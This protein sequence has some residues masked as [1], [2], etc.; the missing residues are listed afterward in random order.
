MLE[1]TERIE[2]LSKQKGISITKLEK[3]LGFS[4]SLIS[5][6]KGEDGKSPGADKIIALS[7]YFGVPTDYILGTDI[8]EIEGLGSALKDERENQ[9]MSIEEVSNIIKIPQEELEHYEENDDISTFVY[10]KLV[11]LY[12]Y[13][14]YEFLNE[15]G[16]FDEYIPEEFDN[17]ADRFIEFKKSKDED[18]N[19]IDNDFRRVARAYDKMPQEEKEKMIGILKLAFKDFFEDDK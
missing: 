13:E 16:L 17:D 14:Y 7:N 1:L 18:V 11:K 8:I 2:M 5:K 12:G 19:I 15:Y 9:N 4:K 10:E 6:W 3:D